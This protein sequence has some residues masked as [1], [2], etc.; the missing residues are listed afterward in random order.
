MWRDIS[1]GV[2][3]GVSHPHKEWSNS[4][5]ICRKERKGQRKKCKLI[6]CFVQEF[7]CIRMHVRSVDTFT[8][9]SSIKP[10][11]DPNVPVV[12][13]PSV[14]PF[15]AQGLLRRTC[16]A[17]STCGVSR[18]KPGDLNL[19]T[20]NPQTSQKVL[21]NNALLIWSCSLVRINIDAML[22][23]YIKSIRVPLE[24]HVHS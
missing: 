17:V 8:Y 22:L 13:F 3:K 9:Y 16:C 14:V 2:H 20:R 18:S 1:G 19:P 6:S 12:T 23:W 7:Y 5:V 15:R 10:G 21:V 11:M 24:A 4:N